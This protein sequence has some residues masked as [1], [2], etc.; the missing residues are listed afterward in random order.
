MGDLLAALS[1]L[2]TVVTILY[3]MWY[4][5]ISEASRRPIDQHTAN[6][7]KDHKECRAVF[8][9]KALPLCTVAVALLAIN[10]WPAWKIVVHAIAQLHAVRPGNYDPTNTT[11]VMVILVLLFLTLHTISA[12]RVLG[13]H[14]WK[15][16]PS[17]G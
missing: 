2:L 10:F 17:H 16:N 6:R 5:E 15:L 8:L 13:K 9:W 3:S 7:V 11:F 14:V 1:L 12:A 4:Q